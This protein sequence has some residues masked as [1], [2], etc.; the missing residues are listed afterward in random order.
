MSEL[1]IVVIGGVAC[2]PKAA[3]TPP[4]TTI[5]NSDMKKSSP[6]KIKI[7]DR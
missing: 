7:P 3:A 4:I 6:Y 2:G 1:K 5:F